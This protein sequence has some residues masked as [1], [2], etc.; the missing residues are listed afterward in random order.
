MNVI[1]VGK[2]KHYLSGIVLIVD[3]KILLVKA[4]KNKND[5]KWSI[6]KGHITNNNSLESA[7]SELSEESGILLDKNYDERFNIKYKKGGFKKN[8]DIFVYYK[9]NKDVSKYLSGW[10]ISSKYLDAKEIVC[11]KFITLQVASE[12]IDESMQKLL[13]KIGA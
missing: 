2:K 1:K 7:L 4:S 6:P 8:M 3:D 12:L 10:N 9:S 5:Y 13:N 11:A